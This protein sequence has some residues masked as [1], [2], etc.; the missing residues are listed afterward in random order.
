MNFKRYWN[1]FRA[2]NFGLSLSKVAVL[3][4]LKHKFVRRT[5][6]LIP[7]K[8]APVF[9]SIFVTSRCNLRCPFCIYGKAENESKH[10]PWQDYEST[11]ESAARILDHEMNRRCLIV[12]FQG[13]EPL[14]NK[15]LPD[16][17]RMTR[18]R[19]KLCG[20][21]TNGLL[22][23]DHYGELLQ[24]GLCDTQI[25]VYDHTI[26]KLSEIL[27]KINSRKPVNTSYPLTQSVLEHTPEQV[28]EI[29][30]MCYQTGCASLKFNIIVPFPKNKQIDY[31]ETI[32]NDN[33]AYAELKQKI[34]MRFPKYPIFWPGGSTKMI[35][36]ASD[37]KCLN[38][39]QFASY[40]AKGNLGLCC[41][42]MPDPT[43]Q[44]ETCSI[45]KLG[46]VIQILCANY[47]S[48][49]L[50][51]QLIFRYFVKVVHI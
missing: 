1:L 21:I 49:Y 30:R 51:I 8:L 20:I 23:Q 50:R 10:T 34:T 27:P 48:S 44:L 31:S 12:C 40:D 35:A 47:A 9:V 39:W 4:Y 14:L 28:E 45:R 5:P 16:M 43:G 13:G 22:L 15:T 2:T 46:G 17:I 37:K 19:G 32:Y 18:R 6:I 29:V 11:V 24:S 33:Q 36:N 26:D 25:S 42:H 7:S 41:A 3:N 38:P